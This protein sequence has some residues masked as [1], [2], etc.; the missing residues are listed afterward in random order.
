MIGFREDGTIRPS[1][2]ITRAAVATI[3]FRLVTDEFRAQVW[4]TENDFTDVHQGQ[5]FNNAVSTMANANIISGM[6]D[7]SFQPNRPITR[8]EFAVL[9]S[10]FFEFNYVDKPMF[11]DVA[12]HWAKNG[13]N[14]LANAGLVHGYDDSTFKPDQNISR[15]EV[16]ALINRALMRLPETTEDLLFG[17]MTVWPDNSNPNAWYY[18]Y[19]QEATNSNEFVLKEDGIHKKWTAILPARPWHLLENIYAVPF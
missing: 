18:L 19:I 15:A 5:W 6:P 16:A 8:G 14:M 9:V 17:E 12:T 10:R 13:I 11:S 3:F 7:G 2:S 4:S 1:S